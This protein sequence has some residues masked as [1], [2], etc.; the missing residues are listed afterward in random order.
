MSDLA[1]LVEDMCRVI[2]RNAFREICDDI[3]RATAFRALCIKR[4]IFP[5]PEADPQPDAIVE[6]TRALPR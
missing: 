5:T 3:Q 2:N 6:D 4:G 1:K